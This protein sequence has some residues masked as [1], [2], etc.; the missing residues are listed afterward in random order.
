MEPTLPRVAPCPVAANAGSSAGGR[1]TDAR[2]V[3][4]A[5]L[6]KGVRVA[7]TQIE[8]G[9]E[10]AEAEPLFRFPKPRQVPPPLAVTVRPTEALNGKVRNDGL[11]VPTLLVE[12]KS[13]PLLD[14]RKAVKR[15]LNNARIYRVV[16]VLPASERAA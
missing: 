3:I 15:V 2:T 13:N 16:K 8:L 6:L 5:D 1:R 7:W 4:P 12:L 11:G 9:N 14:H 10:P